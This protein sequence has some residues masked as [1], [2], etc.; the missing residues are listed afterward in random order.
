MTHDDEKWQIDAASQALDRAIAELRKL[1]G[2]TMARESDGA[3]DA[4]PHEPIPPFCSF[5]GKGKNEVS[6][7]VAGP[8]VCICNECVSFCQDIISESKRTR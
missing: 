3:N 7:I 2:H 1:E 4:I 5:C 6:Q 8:G